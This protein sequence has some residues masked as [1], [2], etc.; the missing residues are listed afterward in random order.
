MST[1]RS[2]VR[3]CTSSCGMNCFTSEIS[4]ITCQTGNVDGLFLCL[5]HGQI[6]NI[7]D[8][9][10]GGNLNDR[11]PNALLNAVPR[12]LSDHLHRC[13]IH[14]CGHLPPLHDR[15]VIHSIKKIESV[16]L[17]QFSGLSRWSAPSFCIITG[18]FSNLILSWMAKSSSAYAT[19]P[20]SAAL[21]FVSPV[22]NSARYWW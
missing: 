20:S 17:Q 13:L 7:L 12:A 16:K 21:L 3:C 2:T 9:G 6:D 1:I 5:D 10:N 18:T 15:H 11:R 8:K 19:R 14:M 22:A 4:S